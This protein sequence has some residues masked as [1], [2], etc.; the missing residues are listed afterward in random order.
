MGRAVYALQLSQSAPRDPASGA[1]FLHLPV[2]RI[3]ATAEVSLTFR[4]S[5]A[6]PQE[7][8]PLFLHEPLKSEKSVGLG[9]RAGILNRGT[10]ARMLLPR[11]PV[12]AAF[13]STLSRTLC[14][15]HPRSV[16][17]LAGVLG[18][19]G[20]L[21]SLR[22]SRKKSKNLVSSCKSVSQQ[23]QLLQAWPDART[24]CMIRLAR[25]RQ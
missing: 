7:T 20:L 25:M 5:P 19:I 6:L 17:V 2:S 10:L 18:W 24:F 12:A 3:A 8:S 1:A 23:I 9:Q 16:I 13:S 4:E 22:G 14:G 21:S 11:M 15:R